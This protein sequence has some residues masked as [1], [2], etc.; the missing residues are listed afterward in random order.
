MKKLFI[1][2]A[3]AAFMMS[4]G[5]SKPQNEEASSTQADAAATNGEGIRVAFVEVDSLMTQ[6][7]FCKDYSEVL[8]QEYANIQKELA[9]KQRSLEQHAASVQQKYENNGFTTRDELDYTLDNLGT[10]IVAIIVLAAV[11]LIILHMRKNKKK[12]KSSSCNCGCSGCEMAGICHPNKN[13]E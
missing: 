1:L 13:K 7:Q 9:S 5:E 3:A 8:A 6:Y 11:L 4:C 12:G 2:A 10:I